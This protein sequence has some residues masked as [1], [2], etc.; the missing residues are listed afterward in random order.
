MEVID[1]HVAETKGR[2]FAEIDILFENKIP[3]R[4][5]GSTKITSLVEGTEVAQVKQADRIEVELSGT[6]TQAVQ[7]A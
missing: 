5:F 3:A 7:L 4:K 1:I 6:G 2:T